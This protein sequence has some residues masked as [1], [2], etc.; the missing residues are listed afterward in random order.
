MYKRTYMLEKWWIFRARDMKLTARDVRLKCS[1]ATRIRALVHPA[2]TA[3]PNL[4]TP[5]INNCSEHSDKNDES[6]Q[7]SV[8]DD[9]ESKYFPS[10]QN[11]CT[12]LERQTPRVKLNC[13]PNVVTMIFQAIMS[14]NLKMEVI[15]RNGF[16]KTTHKCLILNRDYTWH[17]IGEGNSKRVYVEVR[18]CAQLTDSRFP[19]ISLY[20]T[21]YAS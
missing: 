15:L 2:L 6:Y 7:E 14:V 8:L 1:S 3:W 9:T 19:G 17:E 16:G 5:W 11:F 20:K 4:K 12:C 18:H 13:W 10:E 21:L